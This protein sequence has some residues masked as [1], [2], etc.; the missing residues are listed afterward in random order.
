MLAE[1]FG[2]YDF[3][4]DAFDFAENEDPEQKLKM[5]GDFIKIIT[6]I[7]KCDLNFESPKDELIHLTIL[8]LMDLENT[9][10]SM[11]HRSMLNIEYY[12]YEYLQKIIQSVASLIKRD[13]KTEQIY[14][15]TNVGD[16]YQ[17]D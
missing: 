1:Q 17:L 4:C 11:L 12:H 16:H 6:I 2:F 15:T 3:Q 7:A 9:Q 8:A 14:R 10:I 13:K 5:L